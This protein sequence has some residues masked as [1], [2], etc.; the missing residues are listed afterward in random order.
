MAEAVGP[1]FGDDK[2]QL[3]LVGLFCGHT[4]LRRVEP[5]CVNSRNQLHTEGVRSQPGA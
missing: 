4:T 5:G 3:F 1:A 2:F